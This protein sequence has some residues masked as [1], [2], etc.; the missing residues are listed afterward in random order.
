MGIKI[1]EAVCDDIV[2]CSVVTVAADDSQRYDLTGGNFS[3]QCRKREVR[4]TEIRLLEKQVFEYDADRY[5]Y[6]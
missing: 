6:K 4:V 5:K 3:H 2:M 1:L